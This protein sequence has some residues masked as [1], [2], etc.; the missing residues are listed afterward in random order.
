MGEILTWSIFQEK[1]KNAINHNSQ[2][3]RQVLNIL[4]KNNPEIFFKPYNN[5]FSAFEQIVVLGKKEILIDLINNV[6]FSKINFLNNKK[7]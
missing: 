3:D 6:D 2:K 1:L 7:I 4:I 5:G